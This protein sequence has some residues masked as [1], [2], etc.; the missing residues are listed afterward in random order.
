M[1]ATYTYT[2]ISETDKTARLTGIVTGGP[3][4][5]I[6]VSYIYGLTTN[7]L[8]SLIPG[9]SIY[10]ITEIADASGNGV[11]LN[12]GFLTGFSAPFVT[13]FGPSTF[14]GCSGLS[15]LYVGIPSGVPT[16]GSG[17][18]TGCTSLTGNV[19]KNV[20]NSAFTV[21]PTG[22]GGL[23]T[24]TP[25]VMGCTT[26]VI[27]ASSVIITPVYVTGGTSSSSPPTLTTNYVYYINST[28]TNIGATPTAQTLYT[29]DTYYLTPQNLFEVDTDIG[30]EQTLGITLYEYGAK[31]K[32]LKQGT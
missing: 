7:A 3:T 5:N 9:S 19:F 1:A 15:Y 11:F 30:S 24:Y 18:F 32:F 25:F 13:T 27:D 28:I 2:V 17:C 4:G 22:G 23:K 14:S 6:L 26:S 12:Q 10:K 20:N 21:D 16:F 8:L 29:T 31:V